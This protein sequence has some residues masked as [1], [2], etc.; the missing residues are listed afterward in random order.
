MN[1]LPL[2]LLQRSSLLPG[3][4]LPS[5]LMRLSKIN[6]YV[7][8]SLIIGLALGDTAEKEYYLDLS[9]VLSSEI[10][11]R[12]ETL[13]TLDTFTLYSSSYH[14]FAPIMMPPEIAAGS[15]ELASNTIVPLFTGRFAQYQLRPE[16]GAQ[17]CPQCLKISAYHRLMWVPVAT[18]ACLDHKC[19][20][21]NRCQGCSKLVKIKDLI[22]ARC[23]KCKAS[24]ME[25]QSIQVENDEFGLFSQSVIQSWF[26]RDALFRSG[27]YSLPEQPVRTLYRLV[28]GIRQVLMQVKP[29]WSYFHHLSIQMPATTSMRNMK[30]QALTPH[31]SY[32]LYATALKAIM[33][34]PQGFYEFLDAYRG[35]VGKGKPSDHAVRYDLGSLYTWL[36]DHWQHPT[37]AFV[38]EAFNEYFIDRYGLKHAVLKS[39]RYR[40]NKDI[41]ER[42]KYITVKEACSLLHTDDDTIKL[43]VDVGKLTRYESQDIHKYLRLD[44]AE[45]LTLQAKW[46]DSL[47]IAEA[48]ALMGAPPEVI[49]GMVE[50]GLLIAE[51]STS[52]GFGR[53]RIN[54]SSVL[55]FIDALT[56]RCHEIVE[57]CSSLID[58]TV[59]SRMYARKSGL[60][61]AHLLLQV[62]K[63][64]LPI[65]YKKGQSFSMRNFFFDRLDIDKCLTGFYAENGWVHKKEALKLLGT[66]PQTL[67]GGST[68]D[69]S[70]CLS[71]KVV[72]F[73]RR[74][75]LK[76]FLLITS[77][78]KMQQRY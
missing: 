53:W 39:G 4:S 2:P 6:H 66:H 46:L 72:T 23:S 25:A 36:E 26:S 71:T 63:G 24:L 52:E 11:A 68:A 15:L 1:M 77:E 78:V 16:F 8:S 7:P 19:L 13:T 38:Q 61:L 51:L 14:S 40:D 62:V 22:E 70:K 76:N 49:P 59:A 12:L 21:V 10:L 5:L 75:R 67:S 69:S 9:R 34:W 44:R 29:D 47:S 50:A 31:Q 57:D 20:L 28:D 60:D 37:F 64:Y 17:F 54:K 74:K 18:A 35:Q 55:G 33:N 3:E 45:V 42:I 58:L 32:C 27:T 30:T 73:L 48:E 56:T 43:L 65:Y 41:I